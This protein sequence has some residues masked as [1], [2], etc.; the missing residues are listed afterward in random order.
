MY[1]YLYLQ[2][3]AR[4]SYGSAVLLKA[5]KDV[6]CQPFF[7]K[8]SSRYVLLQRAPWPCLKLVIL[9]V[10]SADLALAYLTALPL[11]VI[12]NILKSCDREVV[13][14]EGYVW[15]GELIKSVWMESGC[16]SM[17]NSSAMQMRMSWSQAKAE[18]FQLD[19]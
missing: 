7:P 1:L 2:L 4:S 12:F 11:T 3:G 8:S 16:P 19:F 15:L 18:T 10:L 5:R 17:K 14:L 9:F 6:L 13:Y